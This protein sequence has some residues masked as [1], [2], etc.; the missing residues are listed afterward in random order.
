MDFEWKF[1]MDCALIMFSKKFVENVANRDMSKPQMK[2]CSK[3]FQFHFNV[4]KV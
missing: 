2:P 3:A 4:Q 1:G